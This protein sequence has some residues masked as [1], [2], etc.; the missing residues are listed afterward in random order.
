MA[1]G[2]L[3][4]VAQGIFKKT[5][6]SPF[7]KD[8]QGTIVG[9][10]M[11][12]KGV[13]KGTPKEQRVFGKTIKDRYRSVKTNESLKRI[14]KFEDAQKKIAEGKKAIKE[15]EK[16]VDTKQAVKQKFFQHS[17]PVYS[18][19]FTKQKELKKKGGRVGFKKGSKKPVGKTSFGML[20]VKAG[21]DKNP[22]PTY[23]DKIA[24]AKMKNKN[25]KKKV[26]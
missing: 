1:V 21:I 4:K 16:L 24:G 7:V 17:K 13:L 5:D 12:Q 18:P 9:T 11:M 2:F 25:K 15:R 23:A 3:K 14:K 10:K 26:I 19:N 6:K 22:N 20:S 8:K